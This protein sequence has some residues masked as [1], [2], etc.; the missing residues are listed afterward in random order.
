MLT[1]LSILLTLLEGL[2]LW[3]TLT[4][5]DTAFLIA[6]V[7]EIAILLSVLAITIFLVYLFVT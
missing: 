5:V 6:Q 4:Q 7:S 1:K 2:N 3:Y